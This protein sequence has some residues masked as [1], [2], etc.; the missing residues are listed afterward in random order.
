MKRNV[1]APPTA[2]APPA[3]LA[4]RLATRVRRMVEAL[5]L[6]RAAPSL[7]DGRRRL[8]ANP[9]FLDSLTPAQRQALRDYRGPEVLGEPR[10]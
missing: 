5:P 10:A 9:G 4:G 2:D 7:H 3:T 1:S 6:W 8:A